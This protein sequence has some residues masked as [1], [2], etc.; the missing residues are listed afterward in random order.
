VNPEE[1]VQRPDSLRH[2]AEVCRVVEEAFA[3]VRYVDRTESVRH[4]S[5]TARELV[6]LAARQTGDEE[7]QRFAKA[8]SGLSEAFDE[9]E[10]ALGG[11]R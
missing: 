8:V 1:E 5:K 11:A 9:A 10:K 4:A 3:E 6:T 2:G 7:M